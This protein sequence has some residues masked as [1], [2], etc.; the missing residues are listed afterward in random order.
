MKS[1]V[2]KLFV[3]L[4]GIT[5]LV[6]LLMAAAQLAISV[7]TIPNFELF[8]SCAGVVLWI[9]GEWEWRKARKE[10]DS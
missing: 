3:R 7:L 5:S 1:A 10:I 4:T 2:F 8:A 9:T 6:V